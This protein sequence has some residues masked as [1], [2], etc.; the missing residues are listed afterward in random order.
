MFTGSLLFLPWWQPEDLKKRF[1]LPV[2]F[3]RM[4]LQELTKAHG[5]YSAMQEQQQ[6]LNLI[7]TQN[8]FSI[9]KAMAAGQMPLLF[10]TEVCETRSMRKLLSMKKWKKV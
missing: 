7:R 4:E 2:I 5:R 8:Y 10:P 6:Q 1:F 9:Y 3:P